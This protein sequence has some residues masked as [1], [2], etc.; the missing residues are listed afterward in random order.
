MGIEI[1]IAW[2]V[3]YPLVVTTLFSGLLGCG[4]CVPVLGGRPR[5]VQIEKERALKA[6]GVAA[7]LES[8]ADYDESTVDIRPKKIKKTSRFM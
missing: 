2:M 5:D 1:G 3:W 8:L 7:T 4:G 6:G